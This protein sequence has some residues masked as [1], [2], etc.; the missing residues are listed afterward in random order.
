M[1]SNLSGTAAVYRGVFST[2]GQRA[3]KSKLRQDTCL[4]QRQERAMNV[5]ERA[6]H[7][8]FKN[9]TDEELERKRK[10]YLSFIVSHAEEQANIAAKAAQLEDNRA[11][12][13]V[14]SSIVQ[15]R[16][17]KRM[18]REALGAWSNVLVPFISGAA[19]VLV[20]PVATSIWTSIKAIFS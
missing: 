14:L 19:G 5:R 3:L 18:R 2:V 13:L 8:G 17:R 6:L 10:V 12:Y 11:D 7:E 9:E 1:P 15:D 20:S 16:Q 4:G